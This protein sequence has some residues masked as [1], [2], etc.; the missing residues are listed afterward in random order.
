MLRWQI[1]RL[2]MAEQ[3]RRYKVSLLYETLPTTKTTYYCLGTLPVNILSTK[4]YIKRKNITNQLRIGYVHI[5]I[6]VC[7]TILDNPTLTLNNAFMNISKAF[8]HFRC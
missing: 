5:L 2:Y 8:R 4:I 1:E 6:N 7:G 3:L